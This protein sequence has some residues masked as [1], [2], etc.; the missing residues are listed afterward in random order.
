MYRIVQQISKDRY[1]VGEGKSHVLRN[2]EG[3]RAVDPFLFHFI[4]LHIQDRIKSRISRGDHLLRLTD[5]IG[6]GVKIVQEFF[7]AAFAVQA[8]RWCSGDFSYHAVSDGSVHGI[9]SY[10]YKAF[11]ENRSAVLTAAFHSPFGKKQ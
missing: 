3:R 4:Q 9:L 10:L 5:E 6:G 8:E 1:G 11:P 7:L 2:G